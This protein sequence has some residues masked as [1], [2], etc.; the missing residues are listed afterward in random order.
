MSEYKICTRCVMDTSDKDITFN[1]E[2]VCSHC[3][4]SD[5]HMQR[6]IYSAEQESDNLSKLKTTILSAKKGKYDCLVGVSGGIDSSYVVYLAW[7]LGLNPLCVHF[8]NG[9]NSDIAVS[10][11]HKLIEKCG[12]DLQTYVID[13]NEF[14]DLQRSFFK[15]GV[16]DIEMLTDHAIA[17][18]M[19]KL[20]RKNGLKYILSGTN[21]AT[22]HGLP[23]SWVWRKQ[24]LK[25]IRHIHKLF[26][27]IKNLKNYPTMNSFKFL[28]FKKLNLGF[29]FIEILNYINYSKNSAIETLMKEFDWQN[30]GGKHYES[31]FTKFYQAYYLPKKFG[32]DK[33]RVHLSAQ[34]RNK[35]INRDQ[36]LSELLHPPVNE[37]EFSNE[38]KYVLKK[39]G[40]SQEEFDQ[41][42]SEPPKQHLDYKSD[43]RIRRMWQKIQ[44]MGI[45]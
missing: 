13:W 4:E 37:S 41:I 29:S 25:N 19:F 16:V 39:L 34:I 38:M 36:A 11:I 33:R 35:E 24:D 31:S 8:D 21:Y 7:K 42:M 20:A 6:F 45:K 40:F 5:K 23:N 30:Y 3:I 22:E 12:F 10:N 44:K 26:G 2:G 15:A 17:A 18:I 9:W 1:D 43:E 28:L 27:S 14:R 32:Y